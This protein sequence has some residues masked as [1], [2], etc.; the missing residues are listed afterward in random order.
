MSLCYTVSPQKPKNAIFSTQANKV[1]D[2]R[3]K[4]CHQWS[5]QCVIQKMFQHVMHQWDDDLVFWSINGLE[6]GSPENLAAQ[7]RIP[8]IDMQ[9]K[10]QYT[11]LPSQHVVLACRRPQ[12]PRFLAC[13]Q[14]H[15]ILACRQ[16][17]FSMSTDAFWHVDGHIYY[18]TLH[19]FSFP[20]CFL[21]SR[22]VILACRRAHFASRRAYW[23][24]YTLLFFLSSLLFGIA[25][26]HVDMSNGALWRANLLSVLQ[27]W[28]KA[29]GAVRREN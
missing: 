6:R 25:G 23:L 2:W 8:R 11:N 5:K 20:A 13:R 1:L 10:T 3:A 12:L 19:H 16:A 26:R 29:A 27:R 7:R 14:A 21:A 24:F 9:K 28:G 4:L 18:F 15:V 17:H 22:A